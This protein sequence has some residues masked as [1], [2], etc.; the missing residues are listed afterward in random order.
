LSK[1]NCKT[2]GGYKLCTPEQYQEAAAKVQAIQE[3]NGMTALELSA[4]MGISKDIIHSIKRGRQKR[5]I[6]SL[7]EKIMG[8]EE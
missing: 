8:F 3:S 5:M 6:V 4:Y 7:W 1:T 2:T